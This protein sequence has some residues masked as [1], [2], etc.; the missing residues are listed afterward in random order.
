MSAPPI[1]I[2]AEN[3]SVRMKKTIANVG[4]RVEK[5]VMRLVSDE[6]VIR[7]ANAVSPMRSLSE[8]IFGK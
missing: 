5:V 1:Q 7:A 3:L 2:D 8:I 6:I 4:W